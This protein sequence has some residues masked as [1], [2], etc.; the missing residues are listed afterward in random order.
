MFGNE[1]KIELNN[2]S[3]VDPND[4]KTVKIIF[5]HGGEILVKCKSFSITECGSTISEYDING[6]C[7]NYPLYICTDE[8][9]AIVY[10]KDGSFS[11]EM[12]ERLKAQRKDFIEE[13]F[14]IGER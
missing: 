3:G 2:L 5:K 14:P 6:I 9:A 12:P 4:L 13:K 11:T 8:I 10:L 1:K 7:G